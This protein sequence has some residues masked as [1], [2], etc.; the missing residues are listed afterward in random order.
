MNSLHV[1]YHRVN[2]EI[3]ISIEIIIAY[4]KKKSE[5]VQRER[6]VRSNNFVHIKPTFLCTAG[7]SC[8]ETIEMFVGFVLTHIASDRSVL[9]A[10]KVSPLP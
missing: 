4:T 6:K 1:D 2:I 8:K 10:R 7:W 9:N 3:I 5:D